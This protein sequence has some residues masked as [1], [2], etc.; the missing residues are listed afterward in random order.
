M[1]SIGFA[2]GVAIYVAI[3]ASKLKILYATFLCL[4]F[5]IRTYV[6]PPYTNKRSMKQTF[7]VRKTYNCMTFTLYT[8]TLTLPRM[9][10]PL[11]STDRTDVRLLPITCIM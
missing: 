2:L 9:T 11:P 8:V 7:L 5:L 6:P 4:R 10:V 1:C 3:L